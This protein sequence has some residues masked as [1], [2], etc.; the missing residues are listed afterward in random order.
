M[1]PHIILAHM[2]ALGFDPTSEADVERAWAAAERGAL[3]FDFV[4]KWTASIEYQRQ[5]VRGL[6]GFAPRE[7]PSGTAT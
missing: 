1:E 2:A 5:T 7:P 6:R 3:A 4:L